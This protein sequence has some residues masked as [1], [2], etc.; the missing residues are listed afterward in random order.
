MKYHNDYREQGR[1]KECNEFWANNFAFIKIGF[2]RICTVKYILLDSKMECNTPVDHKSC[3]LYGL[4][5]SINIHKLRF[6]WKTNVLTNALMILSVCIEKT[7]LQMKHFTFCFLHSHIKHNYSKENK[8][9]LG[10]DLN[11]NRRTLNSMKF[12]TQCLPIDMIK[13][14]RHRFSIH[15]LYP[16]YRCIGNFNMEH[17]TQPPCTFE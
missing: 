4:S 11:R 8:G 2:C 1:I 6:E 15:S 17:G 12:V 3:G 9:N 7:Q 5:K 16:L 14:T 13:L 10:R